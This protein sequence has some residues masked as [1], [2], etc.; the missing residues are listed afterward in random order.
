MMIYGF[1]VSKAKKRSFCQCISSS[2]AVGYVT[3]T[4]YLLNCRKDGVGVPLRCD[5]V[6][7]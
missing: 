4:P 1:D 2:G 6:I 5:M 3:V 7:R